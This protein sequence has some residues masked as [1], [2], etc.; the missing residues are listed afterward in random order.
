VFKHYN[1]NYFIAF[2]VACTPTTAIRPGQVGAAA[3]ATGS[4]AQRSGV[5]AGVSPSIERQ[6]I[7]RSQR[8]PAS[9]SSNVD[10]SSIKTNELDEYVRK[11]KS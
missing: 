7:G 1:F 5:A 9:A 11:L 3:R 6:N 10:A 2:G 4:T 8:I